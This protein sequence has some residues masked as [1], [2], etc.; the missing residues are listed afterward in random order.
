MWSKILC[1]TAQVFRLI[2]MGV[3]LC[4]FVY[5]Y[6]NFP[7]LTFHFGEGAHWVFIPSAT[8]KSGRWYYPGVAGIWPGFL[9]S[10]KPLEAQLFKPK[11]IKI[12]YA[13]SNTVNV[14]V[15]WQRFY[16][17][18]DFG[19]LVYAQ[20]EVKNGSRIFCF[21]NLATLHFARFEY[22]FSFLEINNFF[23]SQI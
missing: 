3:K 11:Y 10:D 2:N 13:Y 6:L 17:F 9:A 22:Q 20:E 23:R 7:H 15:K 14:F 18:S 8:N 16:S 5:L 1:K 4:G 19:K 21:L 12:A